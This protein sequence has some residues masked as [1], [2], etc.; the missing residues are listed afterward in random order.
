[1]ANISKEIVQKAIRRAT[2]PNGTELST[3]FEKREFLECIEA[4]KFVMDNKDQLEDLLSSCLQEFP[5]TEK[6]FGNLIKARLKQDE[7]LTSPIISMIFLNEC[8]ILEQRLNDIQTIKGIELLGREYAG[9]NEKSKGK[10]TDETIRNLNAEILT[11]DFLIKE[12]FINISKVS[13]KDKS[14]HQIDIIAEKD[15]KSYA[16]E[17]TRKREIVDW[18]IDDATNLEDCRNL[19]N[20]VKICYHIIQALND[21]NKQFR[22][23]ITDGTIQSSHIKVLALKTSDYGF[24]EC[25]EQAKIIASELL[26][27]RQR[28]EN[29]DG[30]WLI[31]NTIEKSHWI[32]R[33]RREQSIN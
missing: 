26:S 6:Y 16:I 3:E 13:I 18:E 20:C 30:I 19:R 24:S 22:D 27:F 32:Y 5:M 10:N 33:K 21:K 9:D 25:I 11:L 17:V 28:W 14:K 8:Q 1:M 4:E 2:M 29:I 31:P 12:K 15:Q 7:I 23:A